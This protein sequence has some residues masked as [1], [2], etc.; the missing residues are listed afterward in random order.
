M[1]RLVLLFFLL[2]LIIR[3]LGQI[4]FPASRNAGNLYNEDNGSREGEVTLENN[5]TGKKK[6]LKK[7]IGDYVDYEEVD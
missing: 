2:F 6:H 4:L 1:I 7:D 5:A 3:I